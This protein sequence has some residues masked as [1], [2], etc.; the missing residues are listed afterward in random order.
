[1]TDIDWTAI[2]ALALRVGKKM[3]R[4]WPGIDAED[5]SQEAL[6]ALVE[7]PEILAD[8]PENVAL[9]TALMGRVAGS[10]ASRERY[11]FTVRS[12]RYLYTPAEIRGLLTHAYWDQSLRETSVPT[13]PDDRTSLVVHE[14]ICIALWDL[15]AA[16]ESIDGVDRLRL[17]RRFRDEEEYPTQAARKACDRAV[18][19]LTQ[20][21]NEHINRTPA[22]HDGPGSRSVGRMPAAA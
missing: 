21:V 11:D 6:T 2:H 9:V 14:N 3:A 4:Q 5:M 1:V 10:Y 15:D 8:F 19:T 16:F 13:G 22:D 17:I 12:A 18:D 20:R 7:R